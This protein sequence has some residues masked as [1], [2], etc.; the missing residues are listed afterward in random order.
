[1]SINPNVYQFKDPKTK[2]IIIGTHG[3]GGLQITISCYN[4]LYDK[5]SYEPKNLIGMVFEMSFNGE[6]KFGKIIS[7]GSHKWLEKK[8]K[9]TFATLQYD[10][11]KLDIFKDNLS[12]L[13]AVA[14]HDETFKEKE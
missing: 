4:Q 7:Y 1:M 10:G 3:V 9:E 6:D 5:F 2:A 11:V 12:A 13:E 14:E 8:K